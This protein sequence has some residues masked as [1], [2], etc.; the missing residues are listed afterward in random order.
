MIYK[1]NTP[2]KYKPLQINIKL[3]AT[4]NLIQPPKM[5]REMFESAGA[6]VGFS[7]SIWPRH[8]KTSKKTWTFSLEDFKKET[9][10]RIQPILFIYI[11]IYITNGIF[12]WNYVIKSYDNFIN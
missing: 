5:T 1:K 2:N 8:P 3:T 9:I 6:N 10:R 11:Y 4:T 7:L 12:R